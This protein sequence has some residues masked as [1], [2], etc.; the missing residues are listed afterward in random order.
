MKKE[1]LHKIRLGLTFL[2]ILNRWSERSAIEITE[3]GQKLVMILD[4]WCI[5]D[6]ALV[7]FLVTCSFHEQPHLWLH[8]GRQ[9]TKH[10]IV[11]CRFLC[12]FSSDLQIQ[13]GSLRFRTCFRVRCTEMKPSVMQKGAVFPGPLSRI[14]VSSCVTLCFYCYSRRKSRVWLGKLLVLSYCCWCFGKKMEFF[15][16]FIIQF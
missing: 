8:G 14:P 10:G 4:L 5:S 12:N 13:S 1:I 16:S 15:V 9:D 7:T 2:C 6:L 11:S 3:T